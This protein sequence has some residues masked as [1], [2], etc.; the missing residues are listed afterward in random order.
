MTALDRRLARAAA[1]ASLAI[2]P[3]ACSSGSAGG[4]AGDGSVQ[5]ENDGGEVD[6]FALDATPTYA[7]TFSAVYGEI[8]APTCAGLFCHG[9]ADAFL[10]MTSKDV[11]YS[12][13][14]GVV[15]H[16]PNCATTGLT[17]VKPG[18]PGA[19]LFYLKVTTPLDLRMAEMLLLART[20]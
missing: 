1:I 6:S 19:S 18:D 13:M 2:A 14:V 5:E 7:P 10:S 4:S 9:G 11:A 8:L 15:S 12:S 17:I 16:G 3:A 20:A